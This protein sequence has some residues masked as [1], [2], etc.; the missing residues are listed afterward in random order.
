MDFRE[1]LEEMRT[2]PLPF[3]DSSAGGKISQQS[4]MLQEITEGARSERFVDAYTSTYECSFECRVAS[5]CT[6]SSWLL[7]CSNIVNMPAVRNATTEEE[8]EAIMQEANGSS[9]C[10][11][12]HSFCQAICC[13]HASLHTTGQYG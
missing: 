5:V 10:V 8:L 9:Q 7:L 11:R 12:L 2:K 6:N 3:L 1:L 4:G 13:V